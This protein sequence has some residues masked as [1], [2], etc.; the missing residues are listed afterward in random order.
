MYL[1]L[2]IRVKGV[3]ENILLPYTSFD[4]INAKIKEIAW[5]LVNKNGKTIE[6]EYFVSYKDGFVKKREYEIGR[7]HV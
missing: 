5:L 1:F 7:A 6:R 4:L 3:K 2:D